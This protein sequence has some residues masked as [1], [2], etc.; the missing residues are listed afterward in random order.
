[1]HVFYWIHHCL[2][3]YILQYAIFVF[4]PVHVFFG[5]MNKLQD[6]KKINVGVIFEGSNYLF[7]DIKI[8]FAIMLYYYFNTP[9]KYMGTF[10]VCLMFP[11]NL[12]P[13]NFIRGVYE[14]M[15]P[16]LNDFNFV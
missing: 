3:K 11:S 1:M 6:F 7:D 15:H 8:P 16:K 9:K 5:S 10:F 14:D 4:E 13:E 2:L 12:V